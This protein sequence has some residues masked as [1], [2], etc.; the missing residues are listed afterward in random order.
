M[1]IVIP[2][3]NEEKRLPQTFKKIASYLNKSS[4]PSEIVLV[5]DGSK[6]KT[7]IVAEELSR[8]LSLKLV[9]VKNPENQGKGAAIKKGML[10]ASGKAILFTDADLSTPIE[11]LENFLPFLKDFEVV[12]GSRKI[13]GA[14]IIVHQPFYREAMGK[15]YSWLARVIVVPGISD[16]TCGFKLFTRRAAKEIFS[17]QMVFNWSFDA[18]ILFLAKKL[19][20]KVKEVPVSWKDSPATKVRLW[21]DVFGSFWGLIKIRWNNF[22]GYYS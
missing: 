4:F 8:R 7:V 9:V 10:A 14:R 15:V 5:D 18:E 1:S 13:K 6:D 3:Y 20:F 19:G 2:A 11:E 12:I 22:R 21:R 16:F 17:R